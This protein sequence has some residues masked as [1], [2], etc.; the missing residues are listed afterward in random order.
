MKT[1]LTLELKFTTADKKSRSLN[2][3]N[4]KLDLTTAEIQ[5]AMDTIVN[6]G[7]FE[8]DGVNPYAGVDSARYVERIVTDILT[9]GE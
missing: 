6:L 8:I 3:R 5:P 7:I 2:I 4:P 1:T 9:P